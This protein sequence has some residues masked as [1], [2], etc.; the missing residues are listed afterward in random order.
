G[1][2]PLRVGELL[3]LELHVPKRALLSV[4][5]A[6]LERGLH[7]PQLPRR[8]VRPRRGRGGIVALKRRRRL[9]HRTL[10]ALSTFSTFST[11]STFGTLS[12][13]GTVST[14]GTFSTV[15]TL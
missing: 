15:S 8:L 12:T 1:D 5:R 10:G 2:A 6:S 7:L 11:V 4:L 13:F 14:F 9:P 3:R